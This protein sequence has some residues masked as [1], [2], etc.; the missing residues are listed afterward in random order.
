[1]VNRGEAWWADFGDPTGSES[2][3][4][5]PVI[6]VSS[7]RFNNSRIATVMVTAVTSNLRLAAAPGKVELAAG[8]GGLPKDCV[9]NVSQTLVVDRPRLAQAP[10]A[11]LLLGKEVAS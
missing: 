7:D 5:R 1:M 3:F 6:V 10:R 9:A 8:D 4:V 2:G 11:A